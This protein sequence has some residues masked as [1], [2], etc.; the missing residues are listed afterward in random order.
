ML[1][2]FLLS[3][4]GFVLMGT[5]SYL[6][7]NSD[8]DDIGVVGYFPLVAVSV[9][10]VAYHIGIGPIPWS[11]SGTY[12]VVQLIGWVGWVNFGFGC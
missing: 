11:Y 12:R 1:T 6:I 10:A 2:Y 7:S 8:Q 9:I 3:V 5:S 4:A